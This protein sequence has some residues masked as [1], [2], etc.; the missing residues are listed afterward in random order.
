MC[1]KRF[2]GSVSNKMLANA[3]GFF[4]LTLSF[5][6]TAVSERGAGRKMLSSCISNFSCLIVFL[7]SNAIFIGSSPP[8]KKLRYG[9]DDG[10]SLSAIS[11]SSATLN[12]NLFM[13]FVV[14]FNSSTTH[15]FSAPICNNVFMAEML[16]HRAATNIKFSSS[17]PYR[18]KMFNFSFIIHCSIKSVIQQPFARIKSS[19]YMIAHRRVLR[20]IFSFRSKFVSS[21]AVKSELQPMSPST[22]RNPAAV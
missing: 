10:Y 20:M 15:G 11:A 22:C 3:P 5:N 16:P 2:S 12:G 17:S 14:C 4:V 9:I 18:F 7:C 13:M 6:S 8:K 21:A 1:A 19:A